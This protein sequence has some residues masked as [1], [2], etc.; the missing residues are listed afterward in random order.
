MK[1][2][3]KETAGTKYIQI[4][5]MLER[6]ILTG[7]FLPGECLPGER[8][9]ARRFG[10]ASLTLR[11]ALRILSERQLIRRQHGKG[12][13]VC[14]AQICREYLE[15]KKKSM[16]KKNIFLFGMH[17]DCTL[18]FSPINLSVTLMRYQGIVETA[19]LLGIPV[20]VLD[21]LRLDG[22]I[23]EVLSKYAHATG[24]IVLDNGRISDK[25]LH[26]CRDA[27]LPTVMISTGE[28]RNDCNM[29]RVN[30][31]S[32]IK[33]AMEHLIAEGHTRIGFV[34]GQ[35]ATYSHRTRHLMYQECLRKAG[36][37][38]DPELTILDS[39]GLPEDGEAACSKLMS[40]QCPPTAIVAASDYRAIGVLRRAKEIG[41]KIP[42]ELR[43]IGYDD[44]PDAA[45]QKPALTTIHNPLY[46]SGAE[47][48]RMVWRKSKETEPEIETRELTPKLIRRET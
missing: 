1:A 5:E 30:A 17:A 39:N 26:E 42:K 40:L 47:A 7:H 31:A 8:E 10:V 22:N 13:F 24:I 4:C 38:P 45:I 9:L 28:Q 14:D 35:P 11:Q 32:G 23:H 41:V 34:G 6:D 43:I 37:T 18:N 15:K 19:F 16:E 44:I 29:V 20:Q 21:T 25:L 27:G 3:K 48:V 46:E 36:I 12:N 2:G 33:L